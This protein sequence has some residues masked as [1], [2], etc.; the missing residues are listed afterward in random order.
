MSSLLLSV[1]HSRALCTRF[2]EIPPPISASFEIILLLLIATALPKRRLVLPVVEVSLLAL[3][4][5][6]QIVSL[7]MQLLLIVA[8]LSQMKP[9]LVV[10]FQ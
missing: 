7:A 9:I 10:V 2:T 8:G 5:L 4:L 3:L 6:E 1:E